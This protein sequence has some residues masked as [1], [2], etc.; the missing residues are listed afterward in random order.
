MLL[1]R[2]ARSIIS[3]CGDFHLCTLTTDPATELCLK[4]FTS[5]FRPK[6]GGKPTPC[7][8]IF[9]D[10]LLK[11]RL[12]LCTTGIVEHSIL[13]FIGDVVI[14]NGQSGRNEPILFNFPIFHCGPLGVGPNGVRLRRIPD[15]DPLPDAMHESCSKPC[16]G[17]IQDI[18]S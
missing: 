11:I 4:I 5:T 3:L 13:C 15:A 9:P 6:T 7:S 8:A 17:T 14:S 2:V 10:F 16:S 1:N 18:I 12:F